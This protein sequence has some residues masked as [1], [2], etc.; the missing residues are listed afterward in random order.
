MKE[1]SMK[2]ERM[3]LFFIPSIVALVILIGCITGYS[4]KSIDLKQTQAW[5]EAAVSISK[6]IG[7][8]GKG[9]LRS[10]QK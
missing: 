5:A 1:E 8:W 4:C 2:T 6:E 7:N 3:A 10:E 9:I